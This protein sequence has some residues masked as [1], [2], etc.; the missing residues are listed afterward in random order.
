MNT[1]IIDINPLELSEMLKNRAGD[2]TL[3]DVREDVEVELCSIPSFTQ[4]RLSEIPTRYTELDPA[5][6]TIVYC[7]AGG[8]SLDAAR[9]LASKGFT[10]V[11]NLAG[12]ILK[13]A[14]DV[15]PTIRKY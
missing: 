6:E 11:K 1:T 10:D 12:G 7:K 3:L 2:F 4:I 14:T 15:D 5:K 8:R 13:W 9:F